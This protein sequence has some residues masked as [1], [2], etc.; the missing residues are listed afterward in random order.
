M[1]ERAD[2]RNLLINFNISNLGRYIINIVK[3]EKMVRNIETWN[4]TIK[5]EIINLIKRKEVEKDE[6]LKI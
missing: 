3:D 2:G 4:T 1:N 5:D 6:M